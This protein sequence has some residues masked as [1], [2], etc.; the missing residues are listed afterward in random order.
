MEQN[1]QERQTLRAGPLKSTL[2]LKIHTG[3]AIRLWEGRSV[4]HVRDS[5]KERKWMIPSLPMFISRAGQITDDALRGNLYAEMWLY[6][7]ECA[8]EK[9]TKVVQ[10]LLSDAER[11]S[12]QLPENAV[13]SDISSTSPVDLEIFSKSPIGYKC[14]WLLVGVDQL[15]MRVL[16]CEHYGFISRQ[17]R[18]KLLKLAGYQVRHI[19]GMATNYRQFAITRNNLNLSS[20]LY[21][22]AARVL[23]ELD[24][25]IISGKKRSSFLSPLKK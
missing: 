23:G 1:R 13:I 16:Q 21:Q 17:Q 11:Q 19:T 15:A 4:Q 18:D 25:D 6:Q 14:V 8:L 5:G 20:E 10:E 12:E 22:Q 9:G 2:T 24:P 3:Y 7:I